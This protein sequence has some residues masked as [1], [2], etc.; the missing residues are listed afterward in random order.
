MRDRGLILLGLIL[1]LAVITGPIWYNTAAGT[2]SAAPKLAKAKGDRCIYDTA[3][4]RENHMDVLI[5]WRDEVVRRGNRVLTV[6]GASYEMSLSNTCLDCHGD[7]KEFCDKCHDYAA[8][9]PY[10]WDCHVEPG[11]TAALAA[12][13]ARIRP[14]VPAGQ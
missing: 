13:E 4:M 5:A 10:C 11:Q 3:Y 12:R 8:V 7:K 9:K 14:A 1:F 6:G 2:N